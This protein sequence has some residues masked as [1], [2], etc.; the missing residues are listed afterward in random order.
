[1]HQ[2]IILICRKSVDLI[3]MYKTNEL[4]KNSFVLYIPEKLGNADTYREQ[5]NT[6]PFPVPYASYYPN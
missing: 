2:R 6:G 1:M 4:F 5:I 3:Y